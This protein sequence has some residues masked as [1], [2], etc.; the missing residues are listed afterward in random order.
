MHRGGLA[1]V[2]V[3][4]AVLSAGCGF[5]LG[6]EPMTVTGS[7][8]TVSDDALADTEYS[9]AVVTTQNATR[10]VSAFGQTREIA[11]VNRVATYRSGSGGAMVLLSA[12]QVEVGSAA[13][14]FNPLSEVTVRNLLPRFDPRYESLTTTGRT[15][16][17]DLPVLGAPREVTTYNG[18]ATVGGREVPVTVLTT[19]FSHQGDNLAAVV[20]YRS[21]TDDRATAETLLANVEHTGNE[22]TAE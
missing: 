16:A 20:V 9:E 17:E 8:A 1:A 7:A 12:P 3:G 10:N 21:G 11:V 18:T 2:A 14:S 15:G 13:V 6:L 4:I 19:E 22:T 5:V